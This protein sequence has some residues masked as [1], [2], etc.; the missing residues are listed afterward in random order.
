M[1]LAAGAR[2][3]GIRGII[4]PRGNVGEATVVS[5]LEVRGA[6][7]LR[8]VAEFLNGKKDLP[9]GYSKPHA[10]ADSREHLDLAD[11]NGQVHA[12]RALEVAAAGNHNLLLVGPPGSGKTMLARRLPGIL[13]PL[14]L[15]EAIET[16]KIHSVAG[17]LTAEVPIVVS[18][19]FRAPHHTVSD[20]GLIGGGSHPRPGE[21]SLAHNG[22]LF[23]DELPEFRRHVL[24]ALR[25]PIVEHA[26]TIS[27]AGLSLTYPARFMFIAAMNPCP[28]GY[29]G[30]ATRSCTCA[31]SVVRR[32]MARVSGPLLDRIDLHVEVPALNEDTLING[33]AAESS[34]VVRARVV[35]ARERQAGRH[36]GQ[37]P[38]ANAHMSPRDTRRFCVLDPASERLLRSAV[39]RLGL[40]A[41]AFQGVLRIARTIADLEAS[42][43]IEAAHVAEAIQYR[44]L[45][46]SVRATHE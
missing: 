13:P 42:R 23:L 43:S 26:L 35:E 44:S 1:P 18:R 6:R 14:S 21:V 30:D 46:R 22:V 28:C 41:R 24:D 2:E 17:L 45:D 16:S 31:P 9:I 20:A 11:V 19:P 37:R 12:R 10:E 38:R 25:E 27:R 32:Y 40:S 29:F 7:D 36:G 33:G 34:A 8:E 39:A 4:I 15:G 3:A 5:D